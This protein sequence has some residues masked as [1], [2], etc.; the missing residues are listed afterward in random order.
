MNTWMKAASFASALCLAFACGDDDD[1]QAGTGGS[2]STG[3]SAG[4][5]GTGGKGS[6]GES[7]T[8][9][10]TS[11]GGANTGGSTLEAGAGAGG[12]GA[13]SGAGGTTPEGGAGGKIAC[14]APPPPIVGDAGGAGGGAGAGG[15]GGASASGQ[16]AI[17]GAYTDNFS[18]SHTV[19]S[20]EWVSGSST[21]HISAFSNAA[22]FIVA[23]NDQGNTYN[24]CLWSRFDW[25]E[26]NG[27]LYYCATAYNAVTEAAALATPAAD[28]TDPETGGCG[29][30]QWTELT[31]E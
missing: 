29:S 7:P 24:P 5:P 12:A 9:G 15:E 21:Y 27:K 1:N 23:Q 28:A 14:E 2:H 6:A 20:S 22:H 10:A 25:T 17:V 18:G 26:A 31:P 19:T 11:E 30:F 4:N 8:G 13:A 3:G 16:L